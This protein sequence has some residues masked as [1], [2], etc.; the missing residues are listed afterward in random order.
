MVDEQ[1]QQLGIDLAQ[2]APGLGTARAGEVAATFP[3]LEEQFDVAV[4]TP[5]S[6]PLV[7]Q[8]RVYKLKRNRKR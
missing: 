8:T 1:R 4:A 6:I 2:D 3:H 5:K 7:V